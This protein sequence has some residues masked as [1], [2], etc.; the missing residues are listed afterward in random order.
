VHQRYDFVVICD[1]FV[2]LLYVRFDHESASYV[3]IIIIFLTK[4]S[5]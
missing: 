3:V 1:L 2:D 4:K 5:C